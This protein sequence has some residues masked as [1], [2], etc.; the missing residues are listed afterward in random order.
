VGKKSPENSRTIEKNRTDS[1]RTALIS[2]VDIEPRILM[3]RGQ[4]VMLDADLAGLYGVSTKR[5]NEQVKRNRSRFPQ[6][7]MFKLHGDE[8]AELVAKCDRFKNMKH[9][10]VLPNAFTE[11]GAVMLANILKSRRAVEM[12]VYVVRAFIRLRE[13][14]SRNHELARRMAELESMITT[15]DKAIQSLF[16]AIRA[17]TAE[18]KKER[19][20]IGF[21]L[22][23][24]KTQR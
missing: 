21:E 1:Q 22:T 19:R 16:S 7:F 11:H 5:L 3:M 12:S 10:T 14:L 20:K 17:L 15:H 4:R 18:P 6:D 23:G 9:S 8:W 24:K 2:S 13:A